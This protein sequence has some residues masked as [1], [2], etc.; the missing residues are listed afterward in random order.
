MAQFFPF[1]FAIFH[2]PLVHL[3]RLPHVNGYW[4][5]WLCIRP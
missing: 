5:K 3:R 4:G 2:F 1:A